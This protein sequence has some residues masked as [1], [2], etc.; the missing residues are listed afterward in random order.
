[1][2]Q[3]LLQTKTAVLSFC[4]CSL[5]VTQNA[6][7]AQT[8][9]ETQPTVT[10]ARSH[11]ASSFN[12]NALRNGIKTKW[13]G[14]LLSI[15]GALAVA[16]PVMLVGGTVSLVGVIVQDVQTSRL[17]DAHNSI[18]LDSRSS[19]RASS[20]SAAIQVAQRMGLVPVGTP[21][22]MQE[23]YV[24]LNGVLMPGECV[25]PGPEYSKIYFPGLSRSKRIVN[26]QILASS[27]NGSE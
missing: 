11:S 25:A 21:Q 27:L 4:L 23:V 26:K 18:Q 16:P 19:N 22:K 24:V 7:L 3:I 17:A 14:V 10:T 9:V 20:S 5:V 1:M 13:A 2:N 8:H 6:A 15:G 12:P